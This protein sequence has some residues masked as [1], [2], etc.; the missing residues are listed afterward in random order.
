MVP[1][2]A[3]LIHPYTARWPVDEK[4]T[5]TGFSNS[6]RA[7]PL[8][9]RAM[10]HENPS[11]MSH[12]SVGT[13]DLE[14]AVAFYDAVLPTLGCKKLFEFPGAVAYG[15]QFPEFWVQKP[16]DGRDAT[17]GNG[18]HFCFIAETKQQVHAFYEAALAA[19]ATED[20]EPGSRPLYGDPYYGGFV[21]DLDGH[22][23]EAAVW[24]ESAG[25]HPA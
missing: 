8:C 9:C 18:V 20:G 19:G 1:A 7:L 25:D 17:A 21:R 24:D 23:I 13:N 14:Q 10:E 2:S 3:S 5:S 11:I 15:K 12:V 16:I 22:K 6:G 4:S